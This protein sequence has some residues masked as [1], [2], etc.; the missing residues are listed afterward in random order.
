M[1][2][3]ITKSTRLDSTGIKSTLGRYGYSKNLFFR[4]IS[5]YIWNGFDANATSINID[6]EIYQNK[7]EGIFRKLIVSDNG[8]GINHQKL[9]IKFE[10]IFDSEKLNNGVWDKRLSAIH[11]KNGIGRLTFFTFA[12]F[13]T[14]ETIY[15]F[16]DKNYSYSMSI[17]SSKLNKICDLNKNPLETDKDTGTVVTFSRFENIKSTQIEEDL[18]AHIKKEFC[19]FLELNKS[20]KYKIVINGANLDYDNLVEERDEFLIKLEKFNVHIRFIRWQFQLNREYS[21]FYYSNE[22]DEEKYNETTRLNNQGDDFH[23]SLYIKSKYFDN[24]NFNTSEESTQS[25][26]SGGA[27]NDDDFKLI[28][29]KIEIFLREKR[30]PFLKKHSSKVIADFRTEG[31]LKTPT[32]GTFE[33]IESEDLE[34][35]FKELYALQPRFFINLKKEQKKIFIGLLDNILKSEN[36]HQ[37][38]KL[39]DE[40]ISLN[41]DEKKEL[42]QLLKVTNFNK[43]IKT[44]TLLKN[45]YRNVEILKQLVFKKDLHANE[46]DHVQKIVEEN[47]WLFGE[48]YHLV[49]KDVTLQ[50]SLEEYLYL[51][52]GM[53]KE[54]KFEGEDKNKRMDIF[55]CQKKNDGKKIKNVIV[56]LKS[57]TVKL[58]RDQC[59]QVDDY[60]K[61]ILNE[62]KFKTNN[63]DWIFILVGTDFLNDGYVEDQLK[64]SI[65]HG[66]N[67][68]IFKADNFKIYAKTWADIF[69]D[70]ELNYN[71][72]TTELELKKENL[73]KELSSASEGVQIATSKNT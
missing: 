3:T 55:I 6:Y 30:K 12:N 52:D 20:K 43:I 72:L 41:D 2:E 23:H 54:V 9:N 31:I 51:L 32:K 4:S 64:N 15:N 42:E 38:L 33:A 1:V 8:K 68:L 44:M 70:F 34:T 26:L 18:I 10:P 7:K 47:Y 58:G 5:E 53:T 73:V 16:N 35:I 66:E 28:M 36:R 29:K 21:K 71:F 65:N 24:F 50:K 14:W 37:L 39:V 25:Q 48:E 49:S 63:T 46:R 57:P 19:W 62:P 11:G 45:R 59:N 27:R 17:D 22:N 67:N 13:A 40:I 61:A 56:E 69:S 60:R